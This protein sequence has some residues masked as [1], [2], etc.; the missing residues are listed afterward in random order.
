MGKVD[1]NAYGGGGERKPSLRPTDA[2]GKDTLVLTVA[3]ARM[4]IVVDGRT[5]GLLEFEE[6]PEHVQWVNKTDVKSLVEALGDDDAKWRGKRVPLLKVRQNNPS[7]G[8]PVEKYMVAP[9]EDW[10]EI[11][12][13]YDRKRKGAAAKKSPA[14]AR[15]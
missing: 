12:G 6:F 8:K 11:F 3:D 5:T 1:P 2:G 15:R 13:A 4:G 7:T 10:D 9:A 14:K